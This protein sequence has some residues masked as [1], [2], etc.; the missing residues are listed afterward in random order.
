MPEQPGGLRTMSLWRQR[1]THVLDRRRPGDAKP[2]ADRAGASGS[3]PA[4]AAAARGGGQM[5]RRAAGASAAVV[6]GGQ[7]GSMDLGYLTPWAT[8]GGRGDGMEEEVA[9]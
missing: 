2:G 1:A 9:V 8:A 3:G 5:R 4:A 7:K 6:G